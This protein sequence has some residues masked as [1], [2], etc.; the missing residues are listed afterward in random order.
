MSSEEL[1]RD[2]P[3]A[4]DLPT[5]R[6]PK[7]ERG[8]IKFE[9]LLDATHELVAERNVGEFSLS[10]VANRAEVAI[11][12]AYHFFPNVNAALVALVHRYDQVFVDIVATSAG[13]ETWH[14][15]LNDQIERSRRYM[16]DNPSAMKLLASPDRPTVLRQSNA[17]GDVD[18]AKAIIESLQTQFK[19]PSRPPPEQLMRL[20][21]A[22]INGVWELSI[23]LHGRI[24]TDYGRESASAVYAYL[25]Q[26]WPERF[27]PTNKHL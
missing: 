12:T 2:K 16:N 11:G 19:V 18:L 14:D 3:D 1:L 21:I 26:Y 24:T 6:E 23:I 7:Q 15:I 25:R 20:G 9:R 5:Y 8:S 22:L 4:G 17:S 27:E 13:A 10:D